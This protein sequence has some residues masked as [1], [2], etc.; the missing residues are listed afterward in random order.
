[1][2]NINNLKSI[3]YDERD[4]IVYEKC[5]DICDNET[6]ETWY[7]YDDK[8][9]MIYY[10]SKSSYGTCQEEW[11][12]YDED[13]NRTY[14]KYCALINDEETCQEEWRGYDENGNLV[15]KKCLYDEDL[16]G[17][18]EYEAWRI[19]DKYGHMVK[20]FSHN[21]SIEYIIECEYDEEGN[22]IHYKENEVYNGNIIKLNEK[23]Y[24]HDEFGRM[25]YY[26]CE[27]NNNLD[28]EEWYKYDDFMNKVKTFHHDKYKDYT[29][30]RYSLF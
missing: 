17:Y 26:K 24:G 12:E 9:N 28:Y 14:E 6:I 5:I 23:Q 15:Y 13:G 20:E 10:K 1:M 27:Y 19:Y 25:V 18:E 11:R 8:N 16:F 22:M 2:E 4:N 3:K 21:E 30:E 7:E 29:I